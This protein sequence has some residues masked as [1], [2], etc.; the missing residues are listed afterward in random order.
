MCHNHSLPAFQ[1]VTSQVLIE[2]KAVVG[3]DR[4]SLLQEGVTVGGR[5]VA[6]VRDHMTGTEKE[7]PFVDL[8]I[9]GSESL[10][11]MVALAT[12]ALVSVMGKRGVHAKYLCE[13]GV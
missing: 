3:K 6:M 2:V 4:G 5:K 8:R 13:S 7:I 1:W 9:K 12:K 10:S 11:L